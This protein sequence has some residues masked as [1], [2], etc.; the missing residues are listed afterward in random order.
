MFFLIFATNKFEFW[1]IQT[2]F[3]CNV[4]KVFFYL[5]FMRAVRHI[6]IQTCEWIVTNIFLLKCY[7]NKISLL[8]NDCRNPYNDNKQYVL[9]DNIMKINVIYVYKNRFAHKSKKETEMK[10]NKTTIHPLGRSFISM[11]KK[12][13]N[14]FK[15]LRFC[16]RCCWHVFRQTFSIVVY[17]A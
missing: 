2:N 17:R 3:Y 12:I 14:L 13:K 10:Y 7:I 1:R 5:K 11:K 15:Y 8:N 9:S 6:I 4:Y 16:T